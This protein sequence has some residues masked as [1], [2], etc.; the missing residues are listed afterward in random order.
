[1]IRA[2]LAASC[3]AFAAAAQGGPAPAQQ[4]P[5][6]TLEQAIQLAMERNFDL[7]RTQYQALSSGQDL[8]TARAAIL[9]HL[10]FNASVSEIRLNE[11]KLGATLEDRLRLQVRI[12]VGPKDREERQAETRRRRTSTARTK[13]KDPRLQLVK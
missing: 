1:M 9:P 8:I 2:A 11:Q 3:I 6:L 13:R 5:A 4:Q 7:R 12:T 10:D